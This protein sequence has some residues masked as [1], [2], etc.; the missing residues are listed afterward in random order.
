M[1]VESVV[2][3]LM[4]QEKE[5]MRQD[6][7]SDEIKII[8]NIVLELSMKKI[9]RPR[10]VKNIWVREVKDSNLHSNIVKFVC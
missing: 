9:M 5:E 10:Q 2:D 1:F 8:E 3:D 7:E 6:S 4:I